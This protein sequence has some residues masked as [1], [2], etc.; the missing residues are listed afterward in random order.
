MAGDTSLGQGG[1]QF[2]STM[3]DCVRILK[4][5]DG[6]GTRDAFDRIL[7][8]YWQPV[9]WCIR[10]G[11]NKTNEDAKDLTQNFFMTLLERQALAQADPGRG[12]FRTFLRASLRNF[13][14]DEHRKGNRIRHGGRVA[15]IP[16]D[17]Q[18]DPPDL[19]APKDA[20][21]DSVFDAE[22]ARSLMA[23][24]LQRLKEELAATPTQFDVFAACD[25]HDA[26]EAP[27]SHE[28]LAERFQLPLTEIKRLLRIN[29]ARLRDLV[30][31]EIRNYAET[32]SEI[33]EELDYLLKIWGRA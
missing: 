5:D 16:R 27:P 31:D 18:E 17:F 4:D 19:Q 21:P 1:K 24:A 33:Q 15:T 29:R 8:R 3:W 7:T 22:W 32:E 20:S 14:T 26:P 11:W 10:I 9:Y 25:L 12:K 23:A 30:V 28:Q 6:P 13:L 2:P